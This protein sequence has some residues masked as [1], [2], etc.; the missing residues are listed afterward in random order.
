MPYMKK[1]FA[2]VWSTSTMVFISVM[3]VNLNS[4]KSTACRVNAR[5]VETGDMKKDKHPNGQSH[6]LQKITEIDQFLIIVDQ[7]GTTSM[8]Y[9]SIYLKRQELLYHCLHRAISC[10]RWDLLVKK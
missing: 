6:H 4:D 3:T 8:K 1:T 7:L 9:S 10:T 5:F 2:G